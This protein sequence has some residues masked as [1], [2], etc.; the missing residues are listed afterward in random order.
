MGSGEKEAAGARMPE[1]Q[2]ARKQGQPS[3]EA[4]EELGGCEAPGPHACSI[5]P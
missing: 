3:R 4:S 1:N 5:V 2:G